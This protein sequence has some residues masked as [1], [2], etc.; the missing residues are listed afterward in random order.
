MRQKL[1][2][3]GELRAHASILS[4]AAHACWYHNVILFLFPNKFS[5]VT[6]TTTQRA[7][8]QPDAAGGHFPNSGPATHT[9]RH[10]S[11]A[12]IYSYRMYASGFNWNLYIYF[13]S[14]A[15]L[16]SMMLRTSGARAC[17]TWWRSCRDERAVRAGPNGVWLSRCLSSYGRSA[18]LDKVAKWANCC[19]RFEWDVDHRLVERRTTASTAHQLL[20]IAKCRSEFSGFSSRCRI[21][22]CL[23]LHK[24]RLCVSFGPRSPN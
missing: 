14:S 8:A 3:S 22:C 23:D 4:Y 6:C 12:G 13:I 15:F 1:I 17:S 21:T 20:L 11:F 10:I 19:C 5:A 9:Q 16:L 7:S 18:R 24:L 2:L